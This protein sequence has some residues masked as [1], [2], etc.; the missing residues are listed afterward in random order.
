MFKKKYSKT[1][2]QLYLYKNVYIYSSMY[3]SLPEMHHKCVVE[4]MH[5]LLF[6][7]YFVTDHNAFGLH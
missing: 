4:Y 3:C 6:L 5:S 7:L 2:F 1:V